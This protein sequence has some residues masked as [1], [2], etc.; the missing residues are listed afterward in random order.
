LSQEAVN[1][2]QEAQLWR[3]AATLTANTLSGSDRAITLERWASHIHQAEGSLWRGLGMLVAGGGLRSAVLLLRKVGMPDCA[4]ALAQAAAEA[5]LD[6]KQGSADAGYTE[7]LFH[8]TGST[9]VRRMSFGDKSRSNT[10]AQSEA[11]SVAAESLQFVCNLM[12]QL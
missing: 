8:H 10:A 6:N 5:Q 9:P 1:V 12:Q 7:N 2:L 3:Y 4:Q 11:N